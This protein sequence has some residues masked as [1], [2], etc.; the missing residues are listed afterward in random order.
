MKPLRDRIAIVTGAS[1]VGR[2]LAKRGGR[3][4]VARGD[5]GLVLLD[6]HGARA[7]A[8]PFG[9]NRVALGDRYV[10]GGP[11]ALP[12][13]THASR[14]TRYAL[15]LPA[16]VA[17][18]VPPMG[19]ILLGELPRVDLPPMQP[20][21]P[22]VA[23]DGVGAWAV[24]AAMTDPSDP[25][26]IYVHVLEDRPTMTQ[27][28]GIA[29]FELAPAGAPG[30]AVPPGAW[31]WHN[32]DACPPGMATAMAATARIV[33]CGARQLTA[34]T[35][36]VRAVDRVTGQRLWDWRGVTVDGLLAG[37]RTGAPRDGEP[38]PADVVI[39]LDGARVV[40]L[41]PATGAERASWRASDGWLP[42]LA[43]IRRPD[44]VVLVSYEHGHLVF[45]SV[46]LSLRPFRS[47]E[48]RGVLEGLFTVGD[49]VA[50]TLTDGTAYLVDTRGE[51]VAAGGLAPGWQVAGDLAAVT[52][53]DA[54]GTDGGLA[55]FSTDGVMRIAA[56]LPG[57]GPI[58]VIPRALAAGAPVA[59]IG[60]P[61]PSQVTVLNPAGQPVQMVELP[62]DAPRTPLVA[63]AVNGA[64]L[65]AAVLA[66]PL[67]LVRIDL[68]RP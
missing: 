19:E 9:A 51:A 41:D 24:G 61:G 63:T 5:G 31:R 47:L 39:V 4:I 65:V 32:A 66:R 6:E 67:R 44:D 56:T 2:M 38:D 48:V 43:L 60:G 33:V 23:L 30:E 34:G 29:A 37:S 3:R 49:R 15:P 42:R 10:L 50:A 58:A 18:P 26:R 57:S 20:L 16:A 1:R 11:W 13:R 40:V 27:G 46:S 64:G 17:A 21:P 35:G 59:V 62:A 54:T 12:A 45:R 52:V 14:L 53:T 22:A 8:E 36:A 7:L 28:A 68:P 25:A 55:A